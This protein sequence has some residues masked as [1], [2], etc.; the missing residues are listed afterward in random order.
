MIPS[1]RTDRPS[2]D[3]DQTAPGKLKISDAVI[4]LNTIMRLKQHDLK[5]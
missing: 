4:V 3:P 2:V 5:S 1:I